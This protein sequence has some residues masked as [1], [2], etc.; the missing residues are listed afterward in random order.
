MFCVTQTLEN[1][2]SFCNECKLTIP[3]ISENFKNVLLQIN[4][5]KKKTFRIELKPFFLYC[6]TVTG[7]H[8]SLIVYEDFFFKPLPSVRSETK[9]PFVPVHDLVYSPMS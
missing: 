9:I 5:S 8:P 6:S 4:K 2:L 1:S 7:R 3:S